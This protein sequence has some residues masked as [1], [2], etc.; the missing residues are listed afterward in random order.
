MSVETALWAGPTQGSDRSGGIR[1]LNVPAHIVNVTY[2]VSVLLHG[3]DVSVLSASAHSKTGFGIESLSEVAC[4]RRK[5]DVAVPP[6][7]CDWKAGFG[8]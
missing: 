4:D 3:F 8:I 6:G 7:K 5:Y 1:N 2:C